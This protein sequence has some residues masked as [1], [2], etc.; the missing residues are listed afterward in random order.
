[1]FFPHAFRAGHL[2]QHRGG[3]GPPPAAAKLPRRRRLPPR[4]FFGEPPAAPKKRRRGKGLQRARHM[5]PGDAPLT[6][7]P[8]PRQNI[9]N[10]THSQS[11]ATRR[12]PLPKERCSASCLQQQQT[13]KT[14]ELQHRSPCPKPSS[15]SPKKH[16][17][18][19]STLYFFFE[20]ATPSVRRR[21]AC[22]LMNPPASAWLYSP[23]SS[24]KLAITGS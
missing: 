19:L 15:P 24:S 4:H 6:P 23:W 14:S 12:T 18:A 11:G 1:M 21:S 10:H 7:P 9:A 8:P 5:H 17:R 20:R 3:P 13:K 16:S 2:H 22:S